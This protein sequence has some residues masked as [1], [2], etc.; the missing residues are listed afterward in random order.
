MES[1]AAKLD[2][3]RLKAH[4]RCVMCGRG[5]VNALSIPFAADEDG[6]VLAQFDC[7]PDW[8][9]YAGILHGG[10]TAAILDAAMM[11]AL[12]AH[13]I[14]AVTAR[15][16]IRYSHPVLTDRPAQ[17]RAW[18]KHSERKLHEVRAEVLQEGR[19]RVRGAGRFVAIT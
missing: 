19:V 14:T 8:E 16:S 2:R 3:T 11:N 12:F 15:L 18:L 9:G 13:G 6:V 17:V 10:I 4:P 1:H 5:P 7:L